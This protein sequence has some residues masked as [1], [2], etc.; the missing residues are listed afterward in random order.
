MLIKSSLR[1]T[2]KCSDQF[3]LRRLLHSP[4]MIRRKDN[5]L[6]WNRKPE[7]QDRN[8]DDDDDGIVLP[9]LSAEKRTQFLIFRGRSSPPHLL[10]PHYCLGFSVCD[11][12][13]NEREVRLGSVCDS[14]SSCLPGLALFWPL[15]SG[16]LWSLGV[17][18][19]GKEEGCWSV[20]LVSGC[21][22]NDVGMSKKLSW[23][24]RCRLKDV[25]ESGEEEIWSLWC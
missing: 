16:W 6:H 17:W 25:W 23:R 4:L 21:A 2:P 9:C 15:F 5:C 3:W 7:S 13:V 11:Q 18:E 14:S 22:R 24:L 8:D 1:K 12:V 19:R 20:F 10:R